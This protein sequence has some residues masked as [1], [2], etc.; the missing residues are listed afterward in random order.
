MFGCMDVGASIF[1]PQSVSNFG[2]PKKFLVKQ[3]F[4]YCKK[5]LKYFFGYVPIVPSNHKQHSH[6]KWQPI[7]DIPSVFPRPSVF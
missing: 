5:K 1:D 4:N 2:L 7:L 6:S 3:I